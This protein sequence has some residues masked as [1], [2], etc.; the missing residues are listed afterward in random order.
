MAQVQKALPH[1]EELA[2]VAAS[3]AGVLISQRTLI[4][5][6]SPIIAAAHSRVPDARAAGVMLIDAEAR[7]TRASASNELVERADA[8]ECDLEERLCRTAGASWESGI[9]HDVAEDDAMRPP[10]NQAL[11]EGST[12]GGL[13]MQLVAAAVPQGA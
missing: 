6:A 13:A 12:L 5:T 2:A 9:V 10:M 8:L 7:M 11:G 1:V 4:E 3:A